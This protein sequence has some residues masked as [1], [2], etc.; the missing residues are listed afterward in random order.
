MEKPN[1]I[2]LLVEFDPE[3]RSVAISGDF[4]RYSLRIKHF[5]SG[6]LQVDKFIAACCE[7]VPDAVTPA[8]E[9]YS[10]YCAWS[11]LDALPSQKRFGSA[12]RQRLAWFKHGTIRY[13][14][15]RVKKL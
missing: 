4:K 10:A 11:D 5:E 1:K 6:P 8:E 15:I 12:M 14:G 3:T 9:L 13:R 2:K 7:L